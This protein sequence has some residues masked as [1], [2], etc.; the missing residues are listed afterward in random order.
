MP[1]T[2]TNTRTLR[3][4]LALLSLALGAAPD[5]M[6]ESER[7]SA[8]RWLAQSE[9]SAAGLQSSGVYAS[10]ALTRLRLAQARAYALL[11]DVDN[12]LS[13][14][15]YGGGS[16]PEWSSGGDGVVRMLIVSLDM[17]EI[18]AS[19]LQAL[20]GAGRIDDAYG[21]VT[22]LDPARGIDAAFLQLGTALAMSGRTGARAPEGLTAMQSAL[23]DAGTAQGLLQAGRPDAARNVIEAV[24]PESDRNRA[25]A[26]LGRRLIA[27]QD[28]DTV[29]A[30]LE[31]KVLPARETAELAPYAVSHALLA[32]DL[33]TASRLTALV[34]DPVARDRLDATL[35]FSLAE[36]GH[37]ARAAEVFDAA[38][39]YQAATWEQA[40]IALNRDA[41]LEERYLAIES[42]W[43]RSERLYQSAMRKL[44]DGDRQQADRLAV[45]AAESAE[46]IP[47][48][49]TRWLA[50]Q[51]LAGYYARAGNPDAAAAWAGKIPAEP[52]EARRLQT[53]AA[54]AVIEAWA[55]AGDTGRALAE[56][57]RVDDPLGRA[58]GL[59]AAAAATFGTDR[60]AYRRLVTAAEE[61]LGSAGEDFRRQ[62]QAGWGGLVTM[63]CRVGD[64]AGAMKT[65]ARSMAAGDGAAAYEAIV[66]CTLESDDLGAAE[67][68]ARAL[69]TGID[70][71]T[72]RDARAHALAQ[73]TEAV[74][75][76]GAGLEAA[77]LLAEIEQK[78]LRELAT[79][80]VAE[81][82]IAQGEQAAAIE[83][84]VALERDDV[85]EQ[86]VGALL[87]ALAA[88]NLL[89]DPDSIMDKVPARY[90]GELCWASAAATGVDVESMDR[91]LEALEQ[92]ACRAFAYAGAAYGR[93]APPAA[94]KPADLFGRL[95]PSQAEARMAEAMQKN[96]TGR[97]M[98]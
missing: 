31:L 36:A 64:T 46:E 33:T 77:S 21:Y 74:A 82:L 8:T 53:K 49:S 14:L 69:P 92:P 27:E 3:A 44:D 39:L 4:I 43:R 23:R 19:V 60:D 61:S 20:A 7:A 84:A 12:T 95:D 56:A 22:R 81:A 66:T 52:E 51:L 71:D 59:E 45:L 85:R 15:P 29:T 88:R 48:G 78:H 47:D 11:G 26:I 57:E 75:G 76:N 30:L 6:A 72:G 16:Q 28:L 50:Y 42:P 38:E 63:Q 41:W 9:T 67:E 24:E 2:V 18:H 55:R 34:E 91:W 65:A 89:P 93:F 87:R 17:D 40:A 70:P 96:A 35:A 86:A 80:A 83:L 79:P 58:S 68:A 5:S 94:R 32:G 1:A 25:V 37:T 10:Y 73:V 62:R 97:G 13:R 98:R 54:A 90:G